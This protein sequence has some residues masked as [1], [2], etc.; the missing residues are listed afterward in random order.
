MRDITKTV[1]VEEAI[2]SMAFFG[3]IL[4][5][6]W[7]AIELLVNQSSLATLFVFFLPLAYWP[8][9]VWI[10]ART[11]KQLRILMPQALLV[12]MVVSYLLGV[13]LLLIATLNND[14]TI[15][16]AMVSAVAGL[17]ALAFYQ[18]IMARWLRRS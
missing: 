16:T 18:W 6:I 1:I 7:P 12:I 9:G 14:V 5:L 10:R 13:G 8:I 11:G 17:A 2:R 4:F 3:I 15:K